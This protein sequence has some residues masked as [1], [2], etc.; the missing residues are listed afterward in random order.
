MVGENH[1]NNKLMQVTT[2]DKPERD[3]QK[4]KPSTRDL[5]PGAAYLL[6]QAEKRPDLF[7]SLVRQLMPAKIDLDV[8]IMSRDLVD[9][10]SQ[11]REQLAQMR[12]VTPEEEED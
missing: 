2:E 12:D 1:E 4:R 7:I 6:E 10:L 5:A 11:R 3:A 9:L 8:S